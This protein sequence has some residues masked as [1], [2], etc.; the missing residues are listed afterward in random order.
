MKLKNFSIFNMKVHIFIKSSLTKKY[1]SHCHQSNEFVKYLFKHLASFLFCMCG[2]Y[3]F[4]I[5]TF[6]IENP[7]LI[8]L[9]YYSPENSDMRWFLLFVQKESRFYCFHCHTHTLFIYMYTFFFIVNIKVTFHK[10]TSHI[11][12]RVSVHVCKNCAKIISY[13]L[14]C[15]FLI[16]ILFVCFCF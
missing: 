8:F 10:I 3:A 4:L 6:W 12:Y 9:L 11:R 2:S 14:N 7:Y 5:Q 15:S 16:T 1:E 13:L